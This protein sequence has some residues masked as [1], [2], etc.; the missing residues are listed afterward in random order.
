MALAAIHEALHLPSLYMT[1]G[2]C[3]FSFRVCAAPLVLA[4]MRALRDVTSGA[5]PA[6]AA[7]LGTLLKA[8]LEKAPDEQSKRRTYTL[9]TKGMLALLKGRK[10][11]LVLPPFLNIIGFSMYI[12]FIRQ[13][14]YSSSELWT[15]GG[16]SFALDLSAPDP[17]FILPVTALVLSYASLDVGQTRPAKGTI[18]RF[19]Q[20]M[21][22]LL[23]FSAPFVVNM[24]AGYFAY[25]IP[26]SMF[27]ICQTIM[28]RR[29]LNKNKH[30]TQQ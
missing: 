23:L 17:T 20:G 1:I 18:D 16:P 28:V 12:S 30:I 3:T 6:I 5:K 13:S 14:Q 27:S 24:P 29:S 7:H 15:T 2:V 25:W 4:Q 21:Q 26:S 9:Y 11:A 10:A 22:S 19:R 8:E